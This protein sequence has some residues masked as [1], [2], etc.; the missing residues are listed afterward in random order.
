MEEGNTPVDYFAVLGISVNATVEQIKEAYKKKARETH[1]DKSSG[2]NAQ[3]L[4][5]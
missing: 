1:P 3:V 4:V 2:D 5:E